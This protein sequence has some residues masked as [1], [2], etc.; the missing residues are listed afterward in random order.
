MSIVK[1]HT[2]AMF[3]RQTI[4]FFNFSILTSNFNNIFLNLFLKL[5]SD[6]KFEIVCMRWFGIKKNI[7]SS[8]F[9][10]LNC[11]MFQ[12]KLHIPDR[13]KNYS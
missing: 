4:Y 9:L 5:N 13:A 10:I 6:T 3:C 12:I 2:Q 1:W 7:Y 11:K 8:D